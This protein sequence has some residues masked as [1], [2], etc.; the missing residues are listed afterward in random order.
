MLKQ[1]SELNNISMENLPRFSIAIVNY[2]TLDLT[3]HCLNL[4]KKHFESGALNISKVAVWVVDNDSQD[5]STVF[6]K[7]QSWINLIERKPI[8]GE[9]GFAAHGAALDL[10]LER[11]DTDYVFLMHTD[12]LVYEPEVFAW[13]LK[14]CTDNEKVVAVG[15]LDQLNRGYLRTVW[16]ISSRFFKH[17]F[18]RIKLKLGLNSKEPKPYLEK[19]I[20]SFFALWDVKKMRRYNLR[21]FMNDRI[22]GYELQDFFISKNYEVKKV[23]PMKLFKFLDHVEAGTVGVV[24]GYSENNRRSRRKKSI[25]NQLNQ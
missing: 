14:K 6:L 13:A 19:Y 5:E 2:K 12:T 23:S 25:L 20:K 9:Q 17:Y 4:L 16:R 8:P 10:I 1:N 22:P 24:S 15:C 7:A 3:R 21:F 11:I 18:R